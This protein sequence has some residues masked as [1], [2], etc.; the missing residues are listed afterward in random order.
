VVTT[1]GSPAFNAKVLP[2]LED[3]SLKLKAS[4][5]ALLASETLQGT[6]ASLPDAVP[7]GVTLAD[8]TSLLPKDAAAQT[9]R[10]P[11]CSILDAAAL[12]KFGVG[13]P[14]CD[15]VGHLGSGVVA[16]AVVPGCCGECQSLHGCV[17]GTVSLK[18]CAS[19]ETALALARNDL[20]LH[21]IIVIVKIT[22][23][24]G[25]CTAGMQACCCR[26]RVLL[27]PGRHPTPAAARLS[28]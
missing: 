28:H 4:A 2:Q 8:L 15:A 1:S 24:A 25:A 3:E 20:Q 26:A 17:A 21:I 19:A 6:F 27:Q 11:F 13:T 16:V 14:P 7:I 9:I 18:P 22:S 5:F 23:C 12:Q 10:S